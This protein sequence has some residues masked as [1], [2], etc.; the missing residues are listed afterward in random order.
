MPAGGLPRFWYCNGTGWEWP[1]DG[2]DLLGTT[3]QD[4]GS[5]FILWGRIGDG[6]GLHAHPY[7][8]KFIKKK[9]GKT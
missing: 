8:P 5:A 1:G 4:G 7:S 9:K 2:V 6:S 3:D